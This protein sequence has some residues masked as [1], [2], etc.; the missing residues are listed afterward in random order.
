MVQY[1]QA[2]PSGCMVWDAGLDR[3]DAESVGSNPT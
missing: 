2:G 3:M 1:H